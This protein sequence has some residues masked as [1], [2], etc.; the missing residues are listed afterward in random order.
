MTSSLPADGSS[1]PV[2][3]L[4][5][6]RRPPTRRA[7]LAGLGLLGAAGLAACSD[8][9]PVDP[10]PAPDAA[11]PPGG[12]AP[13]TTTAPAATWTG[14]ARAVALCA[15]LSALAA[16]LYGE[17]GTLAGQGRYGA[18]PA[19]AAAFLTTAAAQHTEH[20]AAWNQV[21]TTAGR[22]AADGAELTVAT[23]YRDRLA[24]ARAPVDLLALAVDLEGVVSA[25]TTAALGVLTEPPAVIVT[26]G[27]APVA[28]M[29][30]ATASFLLGRPPAVPGDPV[31]GALGSDALTG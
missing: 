2:G 19:A 25:T 10:G 20:V 5:S 16:S 28:A 14:E 1:S 15:A 29:R 31:A 11:P 17:A 8:A 6:D 27:A 22:P 3:V 12:P 30:A 4:S 7:F 24:G 9:A 26:A 23:R 18:L 13:T 21:L